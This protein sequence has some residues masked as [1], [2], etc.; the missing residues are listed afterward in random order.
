MRLFLTRYLLKIKNYI[1]IIQIHFGNNK[2]FRKKFRLVF[3]KT[4]LPASILRK[5]NLDLIFQ[6][7]SL[8]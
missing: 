1:F 3:V 8:Q 5:L 4:I 6:P 2:I 7:N